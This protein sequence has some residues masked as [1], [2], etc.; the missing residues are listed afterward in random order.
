VSAREKQI[1]P[2]ILAQDQAELYSLYFV[3]R[4]STL[5]YSAIVLVLSLK[6]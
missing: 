4:C 3:F 2:V 1:F 5:V 6:P